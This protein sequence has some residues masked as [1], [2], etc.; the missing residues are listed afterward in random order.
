MLEATHVKCHQQ[1]Y[2]NNSNK[3]A[4]V[5]GEKATRPQPYTKNYRQLRK[6]GVGEVVFP[7]KENTNYLSLIKQFRDL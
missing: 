2:Q 6:P 7:R 1:D 5:N 3:H 4:I